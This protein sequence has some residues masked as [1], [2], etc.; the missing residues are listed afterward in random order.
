MANNSAW[1]ILVGV[2]LDT[3]AKKIQEQLDK[4][5]KNTTVNL[6][7]KRAKKNVDSLA[8]SVEDLGLTYQAANAIMQTSLDIIS[9]MI[10]QTFELDTVLT[11]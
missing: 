9:S 11:E 5:S 1:S 2:E 8:S 7:T 6:D 4:V 10:E 3:N